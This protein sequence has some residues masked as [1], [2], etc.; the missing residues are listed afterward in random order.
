M[1]KTNIYKI[2]GRLKSRKKQSKL[3]EYNL[4]KLQVN[5]NIDINPK[6]YNILDIG[7]GSGE[8]AI[9]LSLLK[10]N[11]K[12]IT[13]E[14]F[15]DGNIN[16]SDAIIKKKLSNIKLFIGNV[17]EFLDIIENKKTFDEIWILFPDPWPKKR[18][19]KRRLINDNFIKKIF[20]FQKN[21]GTLFIS[22]DSPNYIESIFH[23][24]YKNKDL[25]FWKNQKFHD[26]NYEF[27]NLPETKYFK[28][29]KKLN[30]KSIFFELKKINP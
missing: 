8:N 2:F 5:I 15:Q 17:L 24:L 11:A 9:N 1:N 25:Y 22:S 26:W 20:S 27:L 30:K 3:T 16:L 29:A 19:H 7:S 6:N 12:I 4:K 18:H 14:L 28:K 13:C 21:N 10:P 23:T